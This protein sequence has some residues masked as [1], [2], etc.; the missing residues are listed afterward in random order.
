MKKRITTSVL[1]LICLLGSSAFIIK[2]QTGIAGFSGSPGEGSCNSCHV[3]GSSAASNVVITSV[4]A[5]TL[6][7]FVPGTIYNITINVS[8]SGFS[9]FGFGCEILDDLSANVGVMQSPGSGVKFLFSGPRKDAVHSTPK[10]GVGQASFTFNWV[11]PTVGDTATIYVAGNAVNGNGSTTGD[12]ALAPVFM[13]LKAHQPESEPTGIK[14][15]SPILTDVSVYPNPAKDA[16]TLAYQLTQT[17]EVVVE[18]VDIYGKT[19]KA[20]VH[21]KQVPGAYSH[22]IDLQGIAP[23]IYFVKVSGN[24]SKLLQKM[25][26]VK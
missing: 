26:L 6:N 11:A 5:F 12:F 2:Y 8:A 19:V 22:M 3:G 14:E 4:P 17:Q 16:T 23:N 7:E 1:A 10:S 21:E 15:N 24:G 18:L 9:K 20:L 25:L 13:Q